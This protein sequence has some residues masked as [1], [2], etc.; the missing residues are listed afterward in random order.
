MRA[1][2]CCQIV[3]ALGVH[4]VH[5]LS[6]AGNARVNAGYGDDQGQMHEIGGQKRKHALEYAT[7]WNVWRDALDDVQI[8]AD[9]RMNESDLHGAHEKDSKPDG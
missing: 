8:D 9:R 7:E 6:H 5:Q 3:G 4:G 1:C 2:R